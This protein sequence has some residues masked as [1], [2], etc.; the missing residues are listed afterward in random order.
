MRILLGMGGKWNYSHRFD[1]NGSEDKRRR[2][3]LMRISWE[4]EVSGITVTDSM[5]MAVNIRREQEC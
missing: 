4:W 5:G 3:V 1:G 2:G